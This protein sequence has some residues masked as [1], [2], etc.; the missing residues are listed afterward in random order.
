MPRQLENKRRAERVAVTGG[1]GFIGSHLCGRLLQKGYQVRCIDNLHRGLWANLGEC[2]GNVERVLADLRNAEE[3]R[4]AL[5]GVDVVYHLASRVGGIGVYVKHAS[6]IWWDNTLIDQNVF[7][8]AVQNHIGRVFY[9]SSGHVYPESLQQTPSGPDLVEDMAYPAM[10]GLSYGW[11]KLMGEKTLGYLV[12]EQPWLHVAVARIVGAYGPNQDYDLDTGSIIPVLCH[13]AT[14]WPEL[15]PFRVWGTGQETRSYIYIDDVV[16]AMIRSVDCL[17]E[18]RCLGPFNLASRGRVTI[19][20]IVDTV[21]QASGKPIDVFYDASVPTRVWGQ[22]AD[23]TMA[24]RLLK[25]W[26]THFSLE[27]GIHRVY[28]DVAGRLAARAGN[29]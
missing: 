7:R 29:P 5:E 11:A 12:E 25:G 3:A 8:A 13:R 20:Q 17:A 24:E 10:P 1:A 4:R 18:T 9:A 21:V 26:Q 27:D 19:S 22:A 15:Q 16:D 2:E 23:T 6:T 14:R 28:R